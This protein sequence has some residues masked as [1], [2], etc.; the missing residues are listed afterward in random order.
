MRSSILNV[1]RQPGRGTGEPGIALFRLMRGSDKR[2]V[3]FRG[4][5]GRGVRVALSFLTPSNIRVVH[6]LVL[7]PVRVHENTVGVDSSA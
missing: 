5:E 7:V 4:G 1:S 3:F 2:C 6:Q